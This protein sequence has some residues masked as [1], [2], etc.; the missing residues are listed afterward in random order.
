[1]DAV[2]GEG[3]ASILLDGSAQA[4]MMDGDAVWVRVWRRR[5]SQPIEEFLLRV[6]PDRL[7]VTN[8]LRVAPT[9]AG[10]VVLD[11]ALYVLGADPYTGTERG[12]PSEVQRVD[13]VTGARLDTFHVPGW[14][15]WMVAGPASVWG[16][17]ER[18]GEWPGPL[19]E[20]RSD[21][22][23]TRVLS[24]SGVD[25]SAHLPP[26]PPRITDARRTEEDLRDRLA[27]AFFGGWVGSDP[28]TGAEIREPY[29]RGIAF[30]DVRLE[31][32]FPNTEVVA[33]FRSDEHPGVLFGR[34]RRI[35]EDDGAY[36]GVI[37]VMDVNLMED[38]EACGYGLPVDPRPDASGVV[39]M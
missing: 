30:D 2:T 7:E 25:L 39:W 26:P 20:L 35:W 1:L 13:A 34:R 21:D 23:Q 3:Q 19:I 27:G 18:R 31:G 15:V 11:G 17:L 28:E 29:I 32:E 16:C 9:G 5:D 37:S 38:V 10:G 22:P 8:E 12:N 24:L 33:L 14:V 6:D 36:S 4:L